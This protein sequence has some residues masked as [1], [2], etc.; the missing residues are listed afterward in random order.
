MTFIAHA[1]KRKVL[2]AVTSAQGRI[3]VIDVE[4]RVTLK[5][6]RWLRCH[7]LNVAYVTKK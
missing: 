5:Q 1:I 3:L 6:W 4:K 2:E 7:L